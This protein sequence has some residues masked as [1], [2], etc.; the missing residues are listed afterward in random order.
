MSKNDDPGREKPRPADFRPGERPSSRPGEPSQPKKPHATLDLKATEVQSPSGS[1]GAPGKDAPK[2]A[3]RPATASTATSATDKVKDAA[4]T[5]SKPDATGTGATAAKADAGKAATSASDMKS[6]APA[7]ASSSGSSSAPAA[8]RSSAVPPAGSGARTSQ[9]QTDTKTAVEPPRAGGGFGRFMSHMAAGIAGA[10]VM[11]FGLD[12]MSPQFGLLSGAGPGGSDLVQRVRTLETRG[13]GEIAGKLADAEARLARVEESAKGLAALSESSNRLASETKALQEKLGAGDADQRLAKLEDMLN[14]LSAAAQGD[15]PGRIPQ[16]AQLTARIKELEGTINTQTAALRRDLTQAVETRAQQAV[17]TGEVARSA[18]ER[19]DRDMAAVK[20]DAARLDQRMVA[21]KADTD[22]I[23]QTLRVVQEE[24]G[25]VR[26]AVDGLKGDVEARL[27][28]VAKPTDVSEAVA[29]VAG[30]LASLEQSLQGVVKSEEDRRS[31]AERIVLS[32]ELAN[33]KRA[34]DRGER[35]GPAL[36]EVRKAA[37]G[38]L[39]LAALERYKDERVPTPVDLARE[40]RTVG[41]AIIDADADPG[42]GGSVVDRLL[43][44]AKS[45]VRVR[46]TNPSPDDKSAEAV[47]GRMELALKEGRLDGVLDEAKTLAPRAQAAGRDW[48]EKVE[49]RHAVERALAAVDG[50]LKASLAG[51]AGKAQN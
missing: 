20:T 36:A 49:A 12:A 2:D 39:D 7:A 17:Q 24:T 35:F 22:R 13:G 33:L 31:N 10:L 15:Q 38:K 9:P 34:V 3:A 1:S 37:G 30:K 44:G 50:Q 27:K 21:L 43:S 11:L 8:S 23:G 4:S 47:V 48:L 6:S 45:V 25:A 42:Q 5:G 41:N 40:F 19:I 18:T 32:L 28:S 46:K 51:A 29:P 14:T 16:L 26:S